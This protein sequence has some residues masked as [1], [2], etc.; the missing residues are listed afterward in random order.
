MMIE[1]PGDLEAVRRF[2][3][4]M[5][6]RLEARQPG[7]T[8]QI[9][10]ADLSQPLRMAMPK[11]EMLLVNIEPR[12]ERSAIKVA[13]QPPVRPMGKFRTA[14]WRWWARQMLK[15]TLKGVRRAIAQEKLP[16]TP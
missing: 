3:L 15:W 1:I 9:Q 13:I 16:E 11:G 8:A 10:Q 4:R 5:A 7:V 6:P 2:L 14:W 12:G